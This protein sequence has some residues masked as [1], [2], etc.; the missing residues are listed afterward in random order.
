MLDFPDHHNFSD[1]DLNNISNEFKKLEE[2]QRILLTTE[3]DYVRNFENFGNEVFYLP[4]K[5]KFIDNE[6]DFNQLI[7]D[8]VRKSIRNS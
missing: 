4:I 8:Y 5:T 3:K 7:L 6:E 1:K 2:G